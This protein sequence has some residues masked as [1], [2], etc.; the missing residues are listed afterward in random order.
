[1]ARGS[2]RSVRSGRA[3]GAEK[4]RAQRRRL[5]VMWSALRH[6]RL[7][8][9]ACPSAPRRRRGFH[10]DDGGFHGPAG[11]QRPPPPTPTRPDPPPTRPPCRRPT[12]SSGAPP[13]SGPTRSGAATSSR[14]TAR[15]RPRLA[16]R[17]G[18]PSRFEARLSVEERPRRADS[19]PVRVRIRAGPRV[20]W[21]PAG[22]SHRPLTVPGRRTT[23]VVSMSFPKCPTE[24]HEIPSVLPQAGAH[25][26]SAV[27]RL[28]RCCPRCSVLLSI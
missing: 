11:A 3:A 23:A 12:F 9:G 2:R 6:L 1:M 5:A 13:G 28:S 20:L 14:L 16:R 8:V 24:P 19:A 18:L 10:E 7:T 17:H 26:P 27:P 25:F 21:P 4:E 15:P 22:R